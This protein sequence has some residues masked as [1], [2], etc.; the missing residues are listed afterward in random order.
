MREHVGNIA[1]RFNLRLDT[2]LLAVFLVPAEIGYYTIAVLLA[3]LIWNVPDSIGVVLFPKV[4]MSGKESAVVTTVQTCRIT[5]LLTLLLCSG[6]AV[7][8]RWIIYI[9]YGSEYLPAYLPLVILLPGILA[10]SLAKILTKYTSGIGKPQYN[11]I[12][13]I[14]SFVINIPLLLLL[15]PKA[16]ILGAGIAS[17]IA[18][19]VYLIVILVYFKKETGCRL[20]SLF[21]IT[22]SDIRQITSRLRGTRDGR[23]SDV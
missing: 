5:F 13:A 14:V 1:Q 20:F 4:A 10:L 8:G 6:M 9:L 11:S 21:I 15:V 16:G 19:V 3:E 7:V 17:S 18:Y 12:S 23:A 22:R 2:V